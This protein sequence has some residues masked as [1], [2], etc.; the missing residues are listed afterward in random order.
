MRTLATAPTSAPA[1]S[2]A[3]FLRRNLRRVLGLTLLTAL[4]A[5]VFALATWSVE[6][7]SLGHASFGEVHN[8]MGYAGASLADFLI[9][10]FGIAV[11]A[12]LAPPALWAIRLSAARPSRLTR[13]RLV[14]WLAAAALLCGAAT[15]LTPPATWPLPTGLGGV[16]GDRVAL[17][18]HAVADS[19]FGAGSMVA[20]VLLGA[21]G[22]ALLVFASGWPAP[23]EPAPEAV[24]DPLAVRRTLLRSGDPRVPVADD[25][26]DDDDKPGLI[27]TLHGASAHWRLTVTAWLSRLF[28]RK[29]RADEDDGF[30][31]M[32]IEVAANADRRREPAMERTRTEPRFGGAE[33]PPL[34]IEPAYGATAD[35]SEDADEDEPFDDTLIDE[36][37]PGDF[38]PAPQPAIVRRTAPAA[39]VA[40]PTPT[41]GSRVTAP[42]PPA[43]PGRRVA[44]ESQPSLL[45]EGPFELPPVRLL[46]EPKPSAKGQQ[47][48][49]AALE[50]NARMLEGVLEDFGVRGQIVNVRPGPVVTLYE[51]EPAPG[52]KSSR[53]IGLADDIAR[54]M[55]AVSARVAVIPGKNAIGI[56]LPNLKR[57]TVYLRE[58]VA[59]AEFEKTKQRLALCLGKTIGG[60]PVIADLARMPHLLVAGTTG[61]GKSVAINT[62]LVSLLYRMTP[63]QCRLIMVDPK[64]LELS[65]YDGIPHL[66][67]PVVTDPKKAVVALKWTVREMEERYRKMSKLGVRNI[68]GFNARVVEAAEKGEVLSRI[69]QTGFDRHSGEPIFEEE[70]IASEPMPF[71]VVIIDE[72]ADLMMVAGKDIEGAVQR[73]AQMAR[74]AGIHIITATQRPSV[75]VITGTIKAN[76]PTRISFQVT[77]KIDSRTILGEMGA[78]QLLG[79]GDM[80]Y[81]AGG[82]RIQRVHGPFISDQ[83]VEAIVAHLKTQGSPDYLEQITV[84]DD[85]DDGEAAGGSGGLDGLEESADLYDRA[86]A[87]VLR[88]RKASTSY[89]QRRL[90]IG[91][92]RAASIVERMEREGI[93]G[94]ANHAGKREILVGGD[95]EAA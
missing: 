24:P 49:T 60:E 37:D 66:L 54:S 32:G 62:F 83:E 28:A 10:M 27:A 47:I 30:D 92:N 42:A 36:M 94:A 86:V 65:V 8:L 80:L 55:S 18:P 87:V 93:V 71:I 91:Y 63:D 38:E 12:F 9:Q 95:S 29:R 81:M 52:I 39:A 76:F 67:A 17:V 21:L 70:E 5:T 31:D 40:A 59:S 20:E 4:T 34:R 57:E 23:A 56:E 7:P 73:L 46:A 43:K 69:V 58:L 11:V 79:Q 13:R 77:S 68:D 19:L 26:D 41:A 88:D 61:S 35:P 64:M 14:A 78:E 33:R 2:E 22:L 85:D 15:V 25:E 51:L 44:R 89:V 75:D 3:G 90:Q 53:V 84:G 82:G 6:D 50:N 48:D 1:S 72:M 16:A 74:A 45:K